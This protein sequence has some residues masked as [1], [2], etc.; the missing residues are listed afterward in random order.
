[1]K[2]VY[3]NDTR[4]TTIICPNCGF[5]KNFDATKYKNMNQRLKARCKCGEMFGFILEFRKHYRKKVKL[6][7]E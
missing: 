1:M 3:V 2:T 4:Q 7:G 6:P 5:A